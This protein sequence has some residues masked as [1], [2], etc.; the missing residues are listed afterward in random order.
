MAGEFNGVCRE[1]S[2]GQSEPVLNPATEKALA[3][4]RPP[5]HGCWLPPGNAAGSTSCP[6]SRRQEQSSGGVAFIATAFAQEDGAA[7]QLRPKLPKLAAFMDEAGTDLLAYMGFPK[8]H[9]S[10]R[11]STNRLERLNGEIKRK[12]DVVGI[13]PNEAAIVHLVGTLLLEQND[14]WVVQR[15][16]YNAS[17]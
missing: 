13:F 2:D 8:D 10:K 6:G 17:S 16:R 14:E 5:P 3:R 12:T 7:G 4:S 11:H 15:C 1:G 9:W